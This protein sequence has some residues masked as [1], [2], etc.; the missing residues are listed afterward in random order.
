MSVRPL[1]LVLLGVVALG[2]LVERLIVTDAEAIEN[3]VAEA[4]QAFNEERF[5]DLLDI[6][7]PDFRFGERDRDG[8]VAYLRRQAKRF[9][10]AGIDVVLDAPRIEGDEATAGARV[11]VRAMSQLGVV[12]VSLRFA[13]TEAGWRLKRASLGYGP[14]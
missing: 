7:N 5:E 1:F 8:T 10:T 9:E 2:F 14:P 6:L 12:P 4:E 3:L 11:R 13:R